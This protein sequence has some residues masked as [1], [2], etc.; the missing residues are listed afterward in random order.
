MTSFCAIVPAAGLSTR[1][2]STTRGR[3]RKQLLELAG[4]PVL[5]HTLRKLDRCDGL[6][7]T[8]VAV[9]PEDR[10]QVAARISAEP[11]RHPVTV[12][13][14]GESRQDS[15]WNALERIADEQMLVAVHDA[16]R[17]FIDCETVARVLA[18]A[19]QHGAA[20]VGLP[21]VDTVKQV[22]RAGGDSN[23]I[24]ATL[25]RE[26]IVLAQTPQ[27]FRVGQLRRAYER[28]RNDGFRATDEASLLE[29]CGEDV[30]VV[31]GSIRNWKITTPA[32]L[33]LAEMM[34]AYEREEA[35]LAAG[36]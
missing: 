12:L 14:G 19:A 28:A 31:P 16:V 9:R 5:V 10:E 26:R 7:Q 8:F 23:R 29:H 36:G 3:A 27:V 18:A 25:P 22:E 21:A 1:M 6:Q 2:G 13:E 30:Y 17:P 33:P 32:D 15:V 20:I 34:L 11:L 4:A 24:T 35:P